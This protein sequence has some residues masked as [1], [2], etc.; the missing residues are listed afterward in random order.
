MK[1]NM[2][3]FSVLLSLLAGVFSPAQV[4]ANQAANVPVNVRV[5][6]ADREPGAPVAGPDSWLSIGWESVDTFAQLCGMSV[7]SYSVRTPVLRGDQGDIVQ[8]Q[9]GL[10]EVQTSRKSGVCLSSVGKEYGDL[11][12]K[13]GRKSPDLSAPGYYDVVVNGRYRGSFFFNIVSDFTQGTI[14]SPNFRFSATAP[15]LPIRFAPTDLYRSSF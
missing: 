15:A 8:M 14:R 6:L 5:T 7:D 9:T 10:I 1:S 12:F 2:S 13:V 11:S 4:F 3:V